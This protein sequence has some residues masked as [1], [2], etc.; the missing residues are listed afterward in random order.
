MSLLDSFLK[1]FGSNRQL[2]TEATGSGHASPSA[3]SDRHAHTETAAEYDAGGTAV[4]IADEPLNGAMHEPK[5]NANGDASYDIDDEFD[6][7]D[8][9]PARG[10]SNGSGNGHRSIVPSP[11]RS[12]QE[13]LNELR[14]NY[15]EVV[16]LVRKVDGHLDQQSR[17]SERML[18]VAEEA[19]QKMDVLP[20]LADSSDRIAGAIEQLADA[21]RSNSENADAIAERIS[22]TATSQLESLQQ[23]TSALQKMQTAI[24]RSGEAEEKMAE[25][26]DGFRTTMDTMSRSTDD[27][28]SAI[29]TMRETD[30][31]RERELAE[32]IGR[33]QK[34]LMIAVGVFGVFA[35]GTLAAAITG[36]I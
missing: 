14:S 28:G 12:K 27:L 23:Q 1:L 32:L 21:V 10:T 26:I 17:R 29:K 36:A 31:E 7:L 3:P 25:S 9:A 34:W 13:L 6:T 4:A 11:I 8:D 15:Q 19:S 18:E 35:L 5:P 16:D 33:S 2:A 20:R 22:K 30:V 24:H